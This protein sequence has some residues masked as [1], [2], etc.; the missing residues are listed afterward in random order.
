MSSPLCNIKCVCEA[1][2]KREEGAVSMGGLTPTS[3]GSWD[4]PED[5]NT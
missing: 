3:Q 1:G 4:P 5:Q 2:N